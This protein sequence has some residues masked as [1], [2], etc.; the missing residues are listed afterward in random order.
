MGSDALPPHPQIS[1]LPPE[2]LSKNFILD[3]IRGNIKKFDKLFPYVDLDVLLKQTIDVQDKNVNAEVF[4]ILFAKILCNTLLTLVIAQTQVRQ[5]LKAFRNVDTFHD[6]FGQLD[7]NTKS[8]VQNFLDGGSAEDVTKK[9]G[10][11]LPPSPGMFPL[12]HTFRG[13]ISHETLGFRA[14]EYG[15]ALS[16]V[17]A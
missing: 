13:L 12:T 7:G 4:W 5:F 3:E 2:K 8:M 9:S 14:D 17:M 16:Y 1:L 15:V 6:A 10:F 11:A